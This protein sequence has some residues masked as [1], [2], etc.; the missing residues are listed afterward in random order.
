MVRHTKD[1]LCDMTR[2]VQQSAAL[3]NERGS[4]YMGTAG[5][6]RNRMSG[7]VGAGAS[8]QRLLALI[9][10]LLPHYSCDECC[11][12]TRAAVTTQMAHRLTTI[13]RLPSWLRISEPMQ[14]WLVV[15]SERSIGHAHQTPT[16]TIR[17][18]SSRTV[19]RLTLL[20]HLIRTSLPAVDVIALAMTVESGMHASRLSI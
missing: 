19:L 2:G 1:V 5:S 4:F 3:N 10:S 9:V 6:Q 7:V 12:H 14:A 16:H 13:M 11:R 8:K 18:D 17:Y 15:G 20:V